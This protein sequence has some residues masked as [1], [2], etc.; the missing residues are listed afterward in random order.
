MAEK[1]KKAYRAGKVDHLLVVATEIFNRSGFHGSGIDQIIAVSGV[2]NT[3]LYRHFRS[4][5]DL[6]VAVLRRIDK[7]HGEAMQ[8]RVE[9]SRY[10]PEDKLLATFD[11]LEDWFSTP[12]FFGCTFISAGNE[13]SDQ[14]S[15]VFKQARLHKQAARDYF[16]SLARAGKLKSPK[17]V[18]AQ[19][20]LLHEGAIVTAHM[21]GDPAVAREAKACAKRLLATYR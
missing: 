3:T 14:S 4:K 2:A 6:I 7:R 1:N 8:Q 18:A 19:I 17:R 11:Y 9:S 10:P 15:V 20:Q 12:S 21:M 16:E 5:E 13:Y